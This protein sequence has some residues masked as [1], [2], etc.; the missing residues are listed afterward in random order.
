MSDAPE[1]ITSSSHQ[2]G[3]WNLWV[4]F[5]T[6]AFAALCLLVWFPRDIGSGF[7]QQNLTGRTVPGD[8]FFPILLVALMVPLAALLILSQ[9][10]AKRGTGGELVG[11]I[12]LENLAFL[13][14]CLILTGASLLVMNIVGPSLIWLTNMTGL[15]TLSGYRAASASFPFDVSGYFFGAT[16]LTCGLIRI[17]RHRLRPSDLLIGAA[18]AAVLILIFDGLLNNIQL[19]PNADL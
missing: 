15:T 14:R 2:N 19:P 3:R 9:L 10:R 17:T 12:S 16:L 5:G 13:G 7:M 18:T 4:G 1:E 11:H 8:S 6:L